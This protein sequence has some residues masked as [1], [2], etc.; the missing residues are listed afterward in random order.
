[1]F[2]VQ[3]LEDRRLEK[4]LYS[5]EAYAHRNSNFRKLISRFHE[6]QHFA[7]TQYFYRGLSDEIKDALIHT[8]QPREL[9]EVIRLAIDRRNRLEKRTK[10]RRVQQRVGT[11]V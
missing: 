3:G 5:L 4:V 6:P 1:V 11:M 9:E 2:N 10:E 8:E 7:L